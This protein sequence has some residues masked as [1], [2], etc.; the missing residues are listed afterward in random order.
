[1]SN[2]KVYAEIRKAIG[3]G[4]VTSYALQAKLP[5]MYSESTIT[6]RLREMG[7]KATPPTDRKKST[8][9]MYSL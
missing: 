3:R 5:R 4:K 8:A 6:R 9:W 7:A 2:L 1:M